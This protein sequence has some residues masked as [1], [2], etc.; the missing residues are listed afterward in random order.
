VLV[1]I[2]PDAA[3]VVAHTRSL[4]VR[5]RGTT[6]PAVRQGRFIGGRWH[7]QLARHEAAQ[8]RT[9]LNIEAD[10]QRSSDAATARL[11][12]GAAADITAAML[13]DRP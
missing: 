5:L 6:A 1:T 13:A 3:R 12:D 11:L 4:L 2:S 9:A 7:F 8:L 10:E